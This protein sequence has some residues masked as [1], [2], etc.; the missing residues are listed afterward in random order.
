[1]KSR[2]KFTV[3]AVV[4]GSL[5]LLA[6]SSGADRL[7][8]EGASIASPPRASE[9]HWLNGPLKISA[10]GHYLQHAN[11]TPFFWLG[12]TVWT[13]FHRMTLG[14]AEKY[15][16]NRWQKGFTIIQGVISGPGKIAGLTSNAN[17]VNREIPFLD[18]NPATPNPAFFEHA[19]A[20]IDLAADK[21]LYIGLLP[22]WGEYVCPDTQDGPKIFNVDN[23][24]IYGQ[25]LGSRYANKPNIVW[26]MGGDRRGNECG[27][28]DPEIWRALAIGIKSADPNHLMTYHPRGFTSS[29][30]WFHDDAWLDFNMFESWRRPKF[31]HPAASADYKRSP[32]KPVVNGEPWYYSRGETSDRIF[33]SQPYWTTLGGGAGYTFGQ[34][35][36]WFFDK[37]DIAKKY[38]YNFLDSAATE[39]VVNWKDFFQS[40]EW[41]KLVPD[42]TIIVSGTGTAKNKDLKVA[43][44][45]VDGDL[46][47]I[48]FATN[49]E[50]AI[51]LTAISSSS[52]TNAKW[53]NPVDKAEISIGTF[54][55]SGIRS[56]APPS[57]WQDALLILTSPRTTP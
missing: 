24:R 18:E 43:S 44:R 48:Y 38:W 47:I 35:W 40:V 1:M 19:D 34:R 17:I 56:F 15:F 25:W 10:N 31:I 22:T 21:N 55:A 13:M 51:D 5:L 37:G 3:S 8:G 49:S 9:K 39:W 26:I 33:R 50:A 16:E 36:I 52:Q 6:C 30:Y 2:G 45:S 57:G 14:D 42:Q 32:A 29:S 12:D 53:W 46:L 23:A 20:L 27:E 28:N 7:I 4:F 41:W 54:P 11:Q